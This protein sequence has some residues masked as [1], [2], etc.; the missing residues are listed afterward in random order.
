MTDRVFD[1]KGWLVE[2]GE[3]RRLQVERRESQRSEDQD[4]RT[5]IAQEIRERIE[6]ETLARD[7]SLGLERMERNGV[8]VGLKDSLQI[9]VGT[10]E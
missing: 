4:T 1:A 10:R 8:L 2:V 5:L 9:I 7:D 3:H 6:M